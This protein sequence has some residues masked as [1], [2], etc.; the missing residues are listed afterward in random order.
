[1]IRRLAAILS[2]LSLLMC[3]AILAS[4]VRSYWVADEWYWSDG[5]DRPRR[6]YR[7]GHI[8]ELVLVRGCIY[9]VHDTSWWH[10]RQFR[11]VA[12]DNLDAALP[13]FVARRSILGFEWVAYTGVPFLSSVS[14]PPFLLYRIVG[15]PHWFLAMCAA[16]PL[17]LPL[18]RRR[19]LRRRLRQGL[20][21]VCGYDLRAN[22]E[23]CPECG[24]ANAAERG[25]KHAEREET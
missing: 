25:R 17:L 20:C 24:T 13:P 3:V 18:F 1:V 14:M 2:V 10:E 23:R 7:M 11:H 15:I 4:W 16:T 6:V 8:Y 22:K 19:R 21:A 12:F 9:V 5:A